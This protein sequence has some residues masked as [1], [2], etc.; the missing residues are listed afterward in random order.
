MADSVAGTGLG[1]LFLKSDYS[2][3]EWSGLTQ[4]EVSFDWST[5]VAGDTIEY[6]LAGWV[7]DGSGVNT[8]GLANGTIISASTHYGTGTSL[9]ASSL[10]EVGSGASEGD[11]FS[12]TIDFATIAGVTELADFDAFGI[13]FFSTVGSGGQVTVDNVTLTA[14][15]E[16]GSYALLA[17]LTCLASVLIRRRH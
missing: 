15:P 12:A 1:Q 10:V 3:D 17:G 2:V 8:F 5:L 13:M 7:N 4:I 6:A 16:P 14:I 11:T 9:L